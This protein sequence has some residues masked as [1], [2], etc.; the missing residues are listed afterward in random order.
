M[1]SKAELT[2][3]NVERK[4]R[5]WVDHLEGIGRTVTDDDRARYREIYEWYFSQLDCSAS[6]IVNTRATGRTG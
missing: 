6:C 2:D 4:V 5:L 3:I 1:S